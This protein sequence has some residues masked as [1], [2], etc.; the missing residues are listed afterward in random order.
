MQVWLPDLLGFALRE[1]DIVAKLLSLTGDFAFISHLDS[2]V[3][4][5]IKKQSND[6]IPRQGTVVKSLIIGRPNSFWILLKFDIL[7]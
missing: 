7:E 5:P 3:G 2:L 6:M 1:A 4:I